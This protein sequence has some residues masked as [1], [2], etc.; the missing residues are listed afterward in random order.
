MIKRSDD[1]IGK[2]A[3]GMAADAQVNQEMREKR[4]RKETTMGFTYSL[5]KREVVA[6][7]TVAYSLLGVT[8]KA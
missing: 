5:R 3:Q 6:K 4:S 1:N 7:W 2:Q 8:A